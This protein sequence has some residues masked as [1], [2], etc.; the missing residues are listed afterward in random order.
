MEI[1]IVAASIQ[2]LS[3]LK[4][5]AHEIH[6]ISDDLSTWEVAEKHVDVLITGVGM[7]ATSY[8]LAKLLQTK[9]YDVIINAGIAG[10]FDLTVSLGSVF[11][12]KEDSFADLG[13]EDKEDFLT[14]SDLNFGKTNYQPHG[15]LQLNLPQVISATVNTVHGN[16]VSIKTFSKRNKAM[17]ESM[18]GAAVFFVCEKEKQAVV[19]I[20]AV[21]NYVEERKREAWEIPLAIKNLNNFLYEML[22]DIDAVLIKK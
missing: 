6:R 10:S 17:L 20:R 4:E 19:Q 18:E 7:V 14:L 16:A 13:A 15:N 12:V 21:S 11:Q 8:H 3:F 2:E 1:V 9:Q 22:L 5:K